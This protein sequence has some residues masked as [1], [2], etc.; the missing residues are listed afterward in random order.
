MSKAFAEP[1]LVAPGA[2]GAL[3]ASAARALCAVLTARAAPV[4]AV[5]GS[6]S[7]EAWRCLAAANASVS[8]RRSWRSSNRYMPVA[9]GCLAEAGASSTSTLVAPGA[10]GAPAA[11][12]ARALLYASQAA[13]VPA[14]A[15]SP[16]A[17]ARRCLAAADMTLS[18]RRSRRSG[19]GSA[20]VSDDC[21]AEVGVASTSPV[22]AFT[23]APG[24]GGA[25]EAFGAFL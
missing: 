16:S 8:L 20:L 25:L 24:D 19:I 13:P 18:L 12:A 1:R 9:G 3:A 2:G 23:V 7:T 22:V 14:V 10:G 21:L 6:S 17:G 4:P 11:S 5:S 15:G